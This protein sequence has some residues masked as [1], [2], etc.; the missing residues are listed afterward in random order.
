M[1]ARLHPHSREKL[2]N[3][4]YWL[5]LSCTIPSTPCYSAVPSRLLAVTQL[6]HPIYSLL[7]SY[8]IPST[9]C[10]SAVPPRLLI[11]T[12]LY[13]PIYSL[14]LSYTTP[15]THCY[16]ATPPHLLA[17]TQLYHPIY[18]LLL[19]Y[20]T[21]STH[22]Y[23]AVPSHLLAVTQL[24][25]PVYLLLCSYTTSSAH[26][27]S[28]IPP[29]LCLLAELIYYHIHQGTLH[30]K[31]LDRNATISTM[32]G[33][34]KITITVGACSLLTLSALL[35]RPEQMFRQQVA[36]PPKKDIQN[37]TV[38]CYASLPCCSKRCLYYVSV[39]N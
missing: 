13:H 38:V 21:P 4:V 23:S 33:I 3:P 30:L 34:H 36:V 12:Q 26:C 2:Y 37:A 28:T 8:T 25:H 17:V 35:H 7:L 6:Y 31:S 10:Y 14:L 32:D 9:R 15:S 22:C 29:L 24:Y 20:T 19:S 1:Q 5:L 39:L 11:V 18:S 27:Y 16:S